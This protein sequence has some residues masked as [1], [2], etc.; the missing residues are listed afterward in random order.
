MRPTPEVPGRLRLH[1]LMQH[2][3]V[4]KF[5][6]PVFLGAGSPP[7]AAVARWSAAET[8]PSM[9]RRSKRVPEARLPSADSPPG[10]L[11][12]ST[13][14]MQSHPTAHIATR[15]RNAKAFIHPASRP[16]SA[17]TPGASSSPHALR[18][19]AQFQAPRT[20]DPATNTRRLPLPF[21][22][23]RLAFHLR[24]SPL[25]EQSL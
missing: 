7:G 25:P 10:I 22:F 8:A 4:L 24:K 21:P 18:L 1:D 11:R 6:S 15:R 14:A 9:Q 20:P 17:T 2:Y 23:V 5:N 19:W 3:C 12:K 16:A 13:A